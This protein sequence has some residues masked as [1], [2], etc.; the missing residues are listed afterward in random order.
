MEDRHQPRH[1]HGEDR[2]RLRE[3]IDR[4]S[5]VLPQQQQERGDERAGVADADPPH[6][7]RQRERPRDRLVDAPDADALG[8]QVTDGDT[9]QQ[10]EGRGK[11]E[12]EHIA[13]VHGALEHDV[14]D[15]VGDDRA[16]VA[17]A[18]R[19]RGTQVS[20]HLALRRSMRRLPHSPRFDRLSPGARPRDW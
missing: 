2:H 3:P 5:P 6:E 8:E 9:E 15:L 14:R 17:P 16:G 10:R 20:G 4:R 11:R 19:Q 1:R 18:L 7:V 13:P 12:S